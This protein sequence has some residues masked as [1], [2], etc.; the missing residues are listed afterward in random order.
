MTDAPAADS[1]HQPPRPRDELR[2]ETRLLA[3][4]IVPFLVA[5][6]A[7]LYFRTDDTGGCSP[8]QSRHE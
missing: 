7:I 5:A 1:H 8:G 2:W 6:F 3:A 4:L